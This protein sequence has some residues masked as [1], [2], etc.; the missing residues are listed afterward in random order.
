MGTAA[1][2]QEFGVPPISLRRIFCAEGIPA[3]N[4]HGL[5]NSIHAH[6]GGMIFGQHAFMG[7]GNFILN[8][9]GAFIS[10]VP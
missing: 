4:P 7:T 3:V 5:F 1:V 9:P 6:L 8:H 2:K 10:I